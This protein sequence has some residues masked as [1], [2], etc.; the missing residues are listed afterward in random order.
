MYRNMTKLAGLALLVLAACV[1]APVP[2]VTSMALFE[3]EVAVQTPN[4]YCIDTQTSRA[5]A[6]FVVIAG[7]AS[8]VDD[9]NRKT[10]PGIVTVQLGE[11]GTAL[12]E[13][14]ESELKAFLGSA[15][16]RTLLGA[17]P[18]KLDAKNGRVEVYFN[19]GG[20][21]PVAGMQPDEWRA[22]VDVAGR[23]VTLRIRASVSVP[24]SADQ[25]Q[26]L[27]NAAI[28]GLQAKAAEPAQNING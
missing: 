10:M 12:V 16:G 7:C 14:G 22:F 21:F 18:A 23:L 13:G 26:T 2:E 1:G 8:V 6:G 17:Q 19:D 3:G 5:R 28:S 9:I 11:P 4:G 24:I 25:A 27:L 20:E 15:E